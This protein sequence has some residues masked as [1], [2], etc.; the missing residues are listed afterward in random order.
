MGELKLFALTKD[1]QISYYRK[2]WCN[3]F[4]GILKKNKETIS[5]LLY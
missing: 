3:T 5:N 2:N 1:V 4:N